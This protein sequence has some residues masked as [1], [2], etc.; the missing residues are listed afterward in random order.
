M[1]NGDQ[2]TNTYTQSVNQSHLKSLICYF[3]IR[4][5]HLLFNKDSKPSLLYPTSRCY[6]NC[7][8]SPKPYI[9]ARRGS[10]DTALPLSVRCQWTSSISSSELIDIER[11]VIIQSF[12][13]PD[14]SSLAA[15]NLLS[16]AERE[17]SS[18]TSARSPLI[19]YLREHKSKCRSHLR[20]CRKYDT[21]IPMRELTT[22]L[23]ILRITASPRD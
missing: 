3:V 8:P 21:S 13:L 14:I 5:R 10:S 12:L 22:L 23:I 15:P 16:L 4:K 19:R 1:C 9:A 17:Q 18:R 7:H 2:I 6:D 20:L 11:Q